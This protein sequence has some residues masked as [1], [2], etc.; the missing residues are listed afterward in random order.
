[1]TILEAVGAGWL[2]PAEWAPG[3]CGGGGTLGRLRGLGTG[4]GLGR[5]PE[6]GCGAVSGLPGLCLP[7]GGVLGG[8]GV[9]GGL[10]G[11]GSSPGSLALPGA[12]GCGGGWLGACRGGRLLDARLGAPPGGCAGGEG[13]RATGL[14]DGLVGCGDPPGEFWALGWPGGGFPGF[15][16]AG[17]GFLTARRRV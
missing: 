12:G 7:K 13:L 8:V 14:G 17:A 6:G 9:C 3:G 2:S 5:V 15:G 1:M 10:C 11:G 16:G 4:L